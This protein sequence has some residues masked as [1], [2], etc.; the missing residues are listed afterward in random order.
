[1]CENYTRQQ[2]TRRLTFCAVMAC[3]FAAGLAYSADI[4]Y[5]GEAVGIAERVQ[6]LTAFGIMALGFIV[7][8]TAFCVLGRYT[9]GKVLLAL[10]RAT[11]ASTKASA[12]MDQAA[13]VMGRVIDAVKDCEHARRQR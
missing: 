11:E 4:P 3:A 12:S 2:L 13:T 6:Q 5:A 7:M 9:L 8:T 10:E 1:M